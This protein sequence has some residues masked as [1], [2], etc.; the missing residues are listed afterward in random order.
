VTNRRPAPHAPAVLRGAVRDRYS[1]IAAGASTGGRDFTGCCGGA[2]PAG[3]PCCGPG[4]CG[5]SAPRTRA[6][7]VGYS[8]KDLGGVPVG[9]NLGLGCGHPTG[10]ASLRPGEVVL[11]LGSGAGIDCF[12]ASKQVGSRGRVIG[13]DMT[14]AMVERARANARAGPYR[15]VDFRLGEIE[16]LPVADRS[17]DVVVSN[18][19]INLSPEKGRVYR[20]AYRALKP[21]G[22]LAISDV[23]ASGSTPGPRRV[24]PERWA[25]CSSGAM[26]VAALRRL[27]R[28]IG[29]TEVRIDP[30]G[31]NGTLPMARDPAGAG[32]W[33]AYISA[34]KG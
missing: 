29:F 3:S 8:A 6:Q 32:T 15:N 4:G 12:L 30:P 21:G 22:R 28:R 19:V 23:V 13:V 5:D 18:C 1:R 27:L 25:S 20:E 16:H 11:D 14:P 24:D 31:R 7:G 34:T 9:A 33:S 17:V 10:L 26:G 2:R